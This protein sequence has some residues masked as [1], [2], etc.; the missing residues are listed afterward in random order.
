[1]FREFEAVTS[2]ELTPVERSEMEGQLVQSLKG[3]M[4]SNRMRIAPRRLQELANDET[5]ALQQYLTEPSDAA[6]RERG[7]R[8]QAEGLGHR[9]IINM[10]SSLRVAG[11]RLAAQH[12]DAEAVFSAVE[13]YTSALME[14]YLAGLEDDLRLEQQR[15]H[16]AYVRSL[17]D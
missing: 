17:N 14:G 3:A 1:M 6:A 4:F 16:E 11:L 10:T 12:G 13:A 15:T 9:S 7:R 5:S 2:L 8:L